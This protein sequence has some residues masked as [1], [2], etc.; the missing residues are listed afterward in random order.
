MAFDPSAGD[1]GPQQPSNDFGKQLAAALATLGGALGGRAIANSQGNPLTQA[2][3]PQVSQ[4]LDQSVAR[5]AYQNPLFQATT[6]GAY[7]M[8]PD[9]A[10]NGTNLS[11][12]LANTVQPPTNGS[13]GG[14]GMGA[15]TAAALGAGAGALGAAALGNNGSSFD[16][17]KIFQAIKNKFGGQI[18]GIQGNQPNAGGGL[19]SGNPGQN[20][21]TGWAGGSGSGSG[22]P[23]L[24]SDPGVYWGASGG[25][26]TPTDPSGG[27]GVGPGMQAFYDWLANQGGTPQNSG[28]PQTTTG[29]NWWDE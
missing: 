24:P 26:A 9:F 8:L 14:G 29:T 25:G 10:K 2:V 12:T 22:N 18:P 5:Q 7:A 21:F 4:L 27:S 23:F 19:P 20:G 28:D 3:P 1:Q 16:L 11:G 13:G 6:Q 17:G 15:G